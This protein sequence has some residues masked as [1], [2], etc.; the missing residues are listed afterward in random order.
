[1]KRIAR[2]LPMSNV[3]IVSFACLLLLTACHVPATVS[4]TP[5]ATLPPPTPTPTALPTATPTPTP[6]PTV[7]PLN[8]AATVAAGEAAVQAH[9]VTPLCLRNE[10][11]DADGVGEWLGLYLHPTEPPQLLGFV[12]DGSSWHELRPPENEEYAGLGELATCEMQ[13]RDINVDGRSEL[14]V[15]GHTGGGTDYLHVFAWDGTHYALLGAFDSRGGIRIENADDDLAE[16]IVVRWQPEGTL[17]WEVVYTWDGLQ[18]AWTWDRYAWFYLDRPHALVTDTPL[19]ALASFYL[20]LNDRDLPAAYSLLSTSVQGGQSYAEWASGFERTVGA[21]VG[22]ARLVTEENGWA[23][24]A[25]QVRARDNVDGRIVLSV[26]D[27]EWQLVE[28]EAGW[29]LSSGSANLLEQW[30]LPYAP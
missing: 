28:T 18:Y 16:E 2:Y 4:A 17:V 14:L 10:D 20:A 22:A 9:G 29:R 8:V 3:L 12:L 1:M 27:V 30:E 5:T 21:E 19:H 7:D 13:V 11:V 25:A 24:V 15:W 26:Y 23:T 6:A